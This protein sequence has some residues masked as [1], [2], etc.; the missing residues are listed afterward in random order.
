MLENFSPSIGENF[1]VLIQHQFG[2]YIVQN[3]YTYGLEE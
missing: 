2:N 1:S 3:F